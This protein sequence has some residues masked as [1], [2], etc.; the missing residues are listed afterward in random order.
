MFVGL[1]PECQTVTSRPHMHPSTREC[2]SIIAAIGVKNKMLEFCQPWLGMGQEHHLSVLN[3]G[4]ARSP[5]RLD[6]YI[7]IYIYIYIKTTAGITLQ[8]SASP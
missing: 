1:S 3:N 8:W 5:L 7:Y 2:H 4:L 6:I